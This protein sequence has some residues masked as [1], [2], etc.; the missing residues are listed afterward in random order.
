MS[1]DVEELQSQI[2]ELVERLDR[3]TG[4][5][6]WMKLSSVT[7]RL[8]ALEGSVEHHSVHDLADEVE[9]LRRTV[10]ELTGTPDDPIVSTRSLDE[11]LRL[12]ER[13]TRITAKTKTADLDTWPA[14]TQKLLQAIRDGDTYRPS[15][16]GDHQQRAYD[17]RI[18]EPQRLD[19]Q[20]QQ[21]FK[22]SAAAAHA[23]AA[24][25]DDAAAWEQART[26]WN[27]AVTAIQ[28]LGPRLDE[29]QESSAAE[30]EKLGLALFAHNAAVP[31]V[32]EGGRCRTVLQTIIRTRLADALR[33]DLLLPGW[34]DR[35]LGPTAP[36]ENTELWLDT[37]VD[38]I[39]YRLQHE[40]TDPVIALGSRPSSHGQR[41]TQFDRLSTSCSSLRT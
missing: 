4:H 40:I 17:F 24:A 16:L 13:R 36:A 14:S 22:A 25:G 11:R 30:R 31:I 27:T 39:L 9:R 19:Q 6:S 2:E 18:A 1:E 5:D 12:L 28:D 38:V 20:R 37:A 15:L 33:D 23:M 8:D 26:S 3:L 32:L 34:F 41:Q 35:V 21:H 10:T 7:D 29:A